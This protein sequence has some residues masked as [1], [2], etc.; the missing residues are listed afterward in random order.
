MKKKYRK[1]HCVVRSLGVWV[2]NV[3]TTDL[4]VGASSSSLSAAPPTPPAPGLEV[5]GSASVNA[6]ASTSSITS[7][8]SQLPGTGEP[9]RSSLTL[10]HLAGEGW[11]S[12][13][14]PERE[15]GRA[16]FRSGVAGLS[17]GSVCEGRGSEAPRTPGEPAS[18]A[19]E[20]CYRDRGAHFR[21]HRECWFQGASTSV[22]TLPHSQTWA[23]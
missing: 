7:I 6:F 13:R 8:A 19:L 23:F 9:S 20:G 2:P 21:L 15:K 22:L 1:H 3:G 12:S 4:C 5:P 11:E 16:V 18:L 10:C 14:V 17:R